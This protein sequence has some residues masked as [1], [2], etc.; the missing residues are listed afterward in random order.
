MIY[1]VSSKGRRVCLTV[2]VVLITAC[3]RV[4]G[5]PPGPSCCNSCISSS[6]GLW[7]LTLTDI[8][9]KCVF[10]LSQVEPGIIIYQFCSGLARG[11]ADSFWKGQENLLLWRRLVSSPYS[12]LLL[13]LCKN[14]KTVCVLDKNRR[15]NRISFLH[16]TLSRFWHLPFACCTAGE[17][18]L[19]NT[20]TKLKTVGILIACKKPALLLFW[21]YLYFQNESLLNSC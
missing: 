11:L 3:C 12:T 6:P 20:E 14:M 19:R 2:R 1:G 21:R 7:P 10:R 16:K 8:I 4:S 17:S 9:R 5:F 18:A 13:Q 15:L